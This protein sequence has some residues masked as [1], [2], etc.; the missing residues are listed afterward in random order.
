MTTSSSTHV[1]CPFVPRRS[2]V[3]VRWYIQ[4]GQGVDVLW[5]CHIAFMM[6]AVYKTAAMARFKAPSQSVI[7]LKESDISIF[8]ICE[9]P[10]YTLCI[11]PIAPTLYTKQQRDLLA[12]RID[13]HVVDQ[14]H[15]CQSYRPD[16]TLRCPGRPID[17]VRQSKFLLCFHTRTDHNHSRLSERDIA[18]DYNNDKVRGVNLGGWFVLEPWITPSIFDVGDT[19]VDEYTYTQSLGKTQA[20]SN[21]QSHWNSWITQSD[22]SA[23]AAAGLNHVRIPI[24]YWAVAPLDGDP[25]VQGQLDVLDQAITWARNAGIKVLLDLHGGTGFSIRNLS[26]LTC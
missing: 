17:F 10:F 15:W 16:I 14:H 13:D 26:V 22:F 3:T 6:E 20:L 4:R 21:L 11:C 18:F 1:S 7:I 25:Y 9:W 5:R 2:L 23:I 24:G 12:L 8:R 19:V